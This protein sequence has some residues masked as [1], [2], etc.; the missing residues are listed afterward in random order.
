[1]EIILNGYNTTVETSYEVTGQYVGTHIEY[2]PAGAYGGSS[3][4]QVTTITDSTFSYTYTNYNTTTKTTEY[5][6]PYTFSNY[7]LT[8]YGQFF[9]IPAHYQ[10]PITNLSSTSSYVQGLATYEDHTVT[11]TQL[12]RSYPSI[13]GDYTDTT[14]TETNYYN[15]FGSTYFDG[16]SLN[17][18]ISTAQITIPAGTL[19]SYV[20]T[21]FSVA[22]KDQLRFTTY[23]NGISR[24]WRDNDIFLMSPI[25]GGDTYE[26][27]V[28]ISS[29]TYL[30]TDAPSYTTGF[31]WFAYIEHGNT[32]HEAYTGGYI[33]YGVNTYPVYHPQIIDLSQA[34][35]NRH[36][37]A[38]SYS[39]IT[40]TPFFADPFTGGSYSNI[41]YGFTSSVGEN[42]VWV[43]MA[44][45]DGAI[46]IYP[47]K[48][49][50][51]EYEIAGFD[52]QYILQV[53]THSASGS[54]MGVTWY[55]SA[56]STQP[57][58]STTFV[59]SYVGT[60][61]TYTTVLNVPQA[62]TDTLKCTLQGLWAFTTYDSSGSHSSSS[63]F[64][65]TLPGSATGGVYYEATSE[66]TIGEY[67]KTVIA[68][69]AGLVAEVSGHSAWVEN[70]FY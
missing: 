36:H 55:D 62:L 13:F 16:I 53:G 1:M 11:T 9:S 59:N 14:I 39:T 57:I 30:D 7:P 31:G 6:D 56:N 47:H 23:P 27:V 25:L 43:E 29:S 33:E 68:N 44:Y 24:D 49:S 20:T 61:Q 66:V 64:S 22:T 52:P 2:L 26:F 60:A 70:I 50:A 32:T 37:G 41:S 65:G 58:S 17:N 35:I 67:G 54:S 5:P 42:G 18:A 51:I 10:G 8:F 48:E 3:Y 19:T 15:R 46:V 38:G 28:T 63:H 45:K 12:Y 69:P 34:V 40:T 4:L 21:S